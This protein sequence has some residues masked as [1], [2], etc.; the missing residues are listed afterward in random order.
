MEDILE[1][2]PTDCD[3]LIVP[4]CFFES[5]DHFRLGFGTDPVVLAEGLCPLGLALDRER[6]PV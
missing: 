1:R 3:T 6:S 2:L 4:G 5:P